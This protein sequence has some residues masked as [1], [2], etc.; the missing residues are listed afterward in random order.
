MV[1][2]TLPAV[3]LLLL[4]LSVVCGAEELVRPFV[5]E[6]AKDQDTDQVFSSKR[7]LN[8][9]LD[10]SLDIDDTNSYTDPSLLADATSGELNGYGLAT[11]CIETISWQLLYAT[12]L[13]VAYGLALITHEAPPGSKPDS[14]LPEEALITVG[15]LLKSYWN[16]ESLLFNPAD[17]P[18]AAS[19]STQEDYPFA[20]TTMVL[21][22]K[23]Q[24]ENGQQSQASASSGQQASG[25]ITRLRRFFAKRL[26]RRRD[27]KED[28]EQP[29]HTYGL[30]CYVD[31]CN[32]VCR[33][34]PPP[35][36][37]EM[38][39]AVENCPVCLDKL[40][41][42]IATP[43]CSQKIDKHCLQK[44][45]LSTSQCSCPLCRGNLSSLAQLPDFR[46]CS[47]VQRDYNELTTVSSSQTDSSVNTTQHNRHNLGPACFVDSCNGGICRRLPP[48]HRRRVAEE[49]ARPIAPAIF[50]VGTTQ[51]NLHT[52]GSNCPVYP[53]YGICRLLPPY[54]FETEGRASS[55]QRAS[56]AAITRTCGRLICRV[57]R[58]DEDGQWQLCGRLFRNVV[59]LVAHREDH[60]GERTCSECEKL[61]G[62]T[63]WDH[64][65]RDHSR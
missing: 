15:M 61:S 14:R 45:I 1:K 51:H 54:R 19:I 65:R 11:T 57:T 40:T 62:R 60:A 37:G 64:V 8:T 2:K 32:G 3:L 10:S 41:D 48:Y 43:C 36:G 52:L 39:Q 5:A 35:S 25:K 16:P 17:E 28:P 24:K 53:C 49:V 55:S 44:V 13:L 56:F 38:A 6:L 22:G 63:L 21:P 7:N 59:V 20:I 27:G 33:F 58:I 50:F 29:Q 42:V 30:D 12:Q 26:S 47:E 31:S 4:P 46:S 34:R 23:S 9:L 18:E